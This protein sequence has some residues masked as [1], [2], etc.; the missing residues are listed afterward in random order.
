MNGLPAD[1]GSVGVVTGSD[2]PGFAL[3]DCH[4]SI[5]TFLG[6]ARRTILVAV[7]RMLQLTCT[8]ATSGWSRATSTRFAVSTLSLNFLASPFGVLAAPFSVLYAVLRP[9][10]PNPPP[11]SAAGPRHPYCGYSRPIRTRMLMLYLP[12]QVLAARRAGQELSLGREG[13]GATLVRSLSW[14]GWGG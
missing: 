10:S 9:H 5:H 8:K 4:P 1:R 3:L 6:L 13:K 14:V 7:P 12:P 11:R 2:L